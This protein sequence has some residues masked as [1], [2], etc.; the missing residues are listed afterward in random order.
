MLCT[1]SPIS[2]CTADAGCLRRLLL[3]RVQWLVLD[4]WQGETRLR[5][6]LRGLS[7]PPCAKCCTRMRIRC[8]RLAAFTSFAS[9]NR[10]R[11]TEPVDH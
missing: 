10:N 6:K 1:D 5:F 4:E 3:N 8:T 9:K 2:E 7:A 11:R